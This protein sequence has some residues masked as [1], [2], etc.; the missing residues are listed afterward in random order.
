MKAILHEALASLGEAVEK[1]NW[2]DRAVYGNF[3]AQTYYYTRHGTRLLALA[4]SRFPFAANDIHR[5]FM[6]HVHEEMGHEV[7]AERDLNFIGFR[8]EDF[9]ELP[10]TQ[11][12]YRTQYYL[13]EHENP[14]SFFGF[15]LALEGLAVA[16]GPWLYERVSKEFGEKSGQFLK[17]HA[18][19]DVDHIQE[20][21]RTL[22]KMDPSAVPGV[23][24]NLELS[25]Y[26]YRK[27]LEECGKGAGAVKKKRAA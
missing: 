13:V 6:K 27:I 18:Q 3:M 26:L 2:S 11:A 15:I 16:K 23:L 12:F 14:W 8:L 25:C 7:L 10:A 1:E 24:S 19:E 17:V 21:E 9:P 22:E 5:R 20:A 4:G